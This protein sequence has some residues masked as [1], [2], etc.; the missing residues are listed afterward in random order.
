MDQSDKI[1]KPEV[2]HAWEWLNL[3]QGDLYCNMWVMWP[4]V[5]LCLNDIIPNSVTIIW[6]MRSGIFYQI[7]IILHY[8]FTYVFTYFCQFFPILDIYSELIPLDV[9]VNVKF[10]IYIKSIS[11]L[12]RT[13][14]SSNLKIDPIYEK[15]NSLC[16]TVEEN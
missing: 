15:Q 16:I 8:V 1:L 5:S 9:A 4:G 7:Y 11:V 10:G 13:L 12:W 2:M 6:I 3:C 14:Q